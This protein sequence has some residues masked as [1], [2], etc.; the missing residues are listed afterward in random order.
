MG[1]MVSITQECS[2]CHHTRKWDSQPYIGRTPA[3][4]LLLSAA[5]FFTGNSFI[6]VSKVLSALQLEHIST[7]TY[8]HHL[9]SY[10][11][12]T[13][14]SH[15]RIEQSLLHKK[16]KKMDGGL[17][18]GG[19]MRADSPGHCAKFGSYSMMELRINRILEIQLVQV[20]STFFHFID[21]KSA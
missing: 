12:P 14:P 8:Y 11:Q 16:L 1:T 4:N 9:S 21:V 5:V 2:G 17:V 20:M 13:L 15:W 18:L 7:T 19:D 6:R 10:L 3:G